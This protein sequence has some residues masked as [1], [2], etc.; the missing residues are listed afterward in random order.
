MHFLCY[1]LFIWVVLE[2]TFGQKGQMRGGLGWG[3]V[4]GGSNGLGERVRT[5]H[6]VRA[7]FLGGFGGY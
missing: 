6:M 5:L 7:E 3:G 1:L 4:G 2:C